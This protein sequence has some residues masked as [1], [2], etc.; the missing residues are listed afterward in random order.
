MK[1][2]QIYAKREYWCY[3]VATASSFSL[4]LCPW[5]KFTKEA[6][7]RFLRWCPKCFSGVN[8][9]VSLLF[10]Y[11]TDI[12]EK[13]LL[14]NTHLINTIHC[15]HNLPLCTSMSPV[16]QSYVHFTTVL[17]YSIYALTCIYA[18]RYPSYQL[19]LELLYL[20]KPGLNATSLPS[21]YRNDP[22]AQ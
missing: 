5:A 14:P 19:S 18:P 8:F 15:S 3:R 16:L 11:T 9:K 22:H 6:S 21:I 13:D 12:I 17:R 10:N 1:L 2:C 7:N 4:I 20:P